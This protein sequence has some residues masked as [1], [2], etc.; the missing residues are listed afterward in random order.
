[1]YFKKDYIDKFTL[2]TILL[3]PISTLLG[4]AITN[5]YVLSLIILSL[6]IFKFE[7]FL[8]YKYFFISSVILC[9]YLIVIANYHF[10]NFESLIKSYLF[11]RFPL[12]AI[13]IAFL[14]YK[15]SIL[16]KYSKILTLIFIF[17][18]FDSLIQFFFQK[19]IFLQQPLTTGGVYR[20]TSVFGEESILGSY[21][22]KLIY[23]ALIIYFLKFKKNNLLFMIFFLLSLI[24]ITITGERLIL[25]KFLLFNIIL[26]SFLKKYKILFFVFF[27]SLTIILTFFFSNDYFHERIIRFYEAVT[28]FTRS[29]YF[30]LFEKA[31]L[32]FKE[33]IFFG[34]G[35]KNFRNVCDFDQYSLQISYLINSGCNTHPHNY[36]LEILS[37]AGIVGFFLFFN[38]FMYVVFKS[39]NNIKKIDY[40]VFL[41]LFLTLLWPLGTNNSFYSSFNGYIIWFNIGILLSYTQTNENFISN[42]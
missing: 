3:F 7:P 33:N 21:L 9:I 39:F 29:Q 11:L 28:N 14:F 22:L 34:V 30:P 10:I 15:Y 26:L 8:K 20:I 2:L 38:I 13:L 23:P 41:V 42:K 5:I 17:L 36:I 1:M 12:L 4:P 40:V 18:F 25:L 37:E 6:L 16:E 19:N 27:F 35:I 24:L 31:Y 32:I